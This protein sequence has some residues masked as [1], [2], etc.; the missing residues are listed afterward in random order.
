MIAGD[1]RVRCAFDE[2]FF[3]GHEGAEAAGV[4]HFVRLL[5][6]EKVIHYTRLVHSEVFI[7]LIWNII[8]VA[9]SYMMVITG[10]PMFLYSH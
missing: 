7:L 4:C 8:I 3:L 6:A 1:W 10:S 2:R 9:N 5:V